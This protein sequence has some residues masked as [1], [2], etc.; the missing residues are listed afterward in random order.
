MY[1]F[2]KANGR[3]DTQSFVFQR[4]KEFRATIDK[5]SKKLGL[6]VRVPC[7]VTTFPFLSIRAVG[8]GAV[9][10]H[11]ARNS[12]QQVKS[13]DRIIEVNG[14]QGDAAQLLACLNNAD[15]CTLTIQRFS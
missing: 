4:P 15:V 2:R 7:P 5:H 1:A 13:Y 12:D 10:D 9:M 14:C 3:I 11:N 8:E 6:L